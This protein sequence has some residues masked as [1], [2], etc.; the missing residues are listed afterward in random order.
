MINLNDI[1]HSIFKLPHEAS[2]NSVSAWGTSA[3]SL[4]FACGPTKSN[5]EIK[6]YEVQSL[7]AEGQNTQLIAAWE[8]PHDELKENSEKLVNLHYFA[9]D[10]SFCLILNGGDTFIV[11]REPDEYQSH[12]EIAGSIDAGIAAAAWSPD[13]ELL[14]L[15][16]SSKSFLLMSRNYDPVHEVEISPND[17]KS[18]N[19]VSVGWGAAETQF[20]GRRAKGLR[21]P[22]VPEKVDAGS[23]SHLDKGEIIISWRGDGA[24]VAI[25]SIDDEKR[26][27]IRVY[28]RDGLLDSISEPLD[29]LEGSL[30]WR[31]SG[32]LLAGVQRLS[33]RASV[34]FF[35]RNGLRHGEFSLRLTK[36]D[37]SSWASE[38]R[39]AWNSDSSI[40]GIQFKDR[41]QLWM[42]KN[43]HYYLK[44]E[45]N[46]LGSEFESSFLMEWHPESPYILHKCYGGMLD[47]QFL[48]RRP[49]NR[50]I[51]IVEVMGYA[52]GF[53]RQDVTYHESIGLVGVVDGGEV[54]YL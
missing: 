17:L 12:V 37:L 47:L 14:A 54:F 7:A 43:Y 8:S 53:T 42:M 45:I 16:T 28:G 1:G 18:S 22:T 34:V 20:K 32:N 46:N 3:N 10:L 44:K 19:H 23:L 40:L 30:S 52:P 38:I 24:Y 11:R 13:E 50:V 29:G 39:L 31:P 4:F 27:T 9:D 26:R 33:D 21:D 35:E 36:D 2:I 48:W 51:G 15:V 5:T 6:L 49:I 41:I 25:N